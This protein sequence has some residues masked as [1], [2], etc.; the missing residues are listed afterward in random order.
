VAYVL[1]KA[2]LVWNRALSDHPG[3]GV[4]DW[5]LQAMAKPHGRIM[6]GGVSAVMDIC[7]AEE[8]QHA[9]DAFAYLGLADLAGLPRRLI[10]ADWW[11]ED[12]IEDR[13]DRT[14]YG[15]DF[16]TRRRF[17]RKYT[18]APEDF[19]PVPLDGVERRPG[20][21]SLVRSQYRPP[22]VSAGHR[23]FA[24]RWYVGH[25]CGCN[26]TATLGGDV[27]VTQIDLDDEA[28]AEAMRLSGAKTK[29]ET[30]NLALREYA[31][32]HRRIAALDRY[33]A[34]AQSWD[35][36]GWQAMRSVDKSPAA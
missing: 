4:G 5:H 30:V 1:T 25:V 23:S 19:D 3:T 27:S 24:G 11:S 14:F 22:P 32:R 10:D 31:A 12:D 18:E 13:L 26:M 36:E 15:L 8:V 35:Y 21:W 2:D 33:A 17:E 7:T 29:K 20:S 9:A 6:N 34:A 28:L 16:R